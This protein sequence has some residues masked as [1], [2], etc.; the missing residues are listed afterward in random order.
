LINF[1]KIWTLN[2]YKKNY[3]FV[4][5]VFLTAI[6]AIYQEPCIKFSRFLPNKYNFIDIYRKKPKKFKTDNVHKQLKIS[7]NIWKI[8]SCTENS[9][10]NIQS[11]FHVPTVI[12]YRVAPK[13]KIGFLENS[14]FLIFLLFFT[15]LLKTTG[16]FL[17]LTASKYQLDSLSYQKNY[18]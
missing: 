14:F 12:C 2:A 18:C 11:K 16:K 8:L 17:L 1:V 13:T 5:L 6:V 4:F 15:S 9:N 10:I 3:A 7:Q